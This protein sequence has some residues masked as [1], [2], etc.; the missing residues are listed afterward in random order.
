[1]TIQEIFDIAG[2]TISKNWLIIVIIL[3]LIQIAPVKISPWSWIGGWIGKIVG[4]RKLSDK[5]DNLENKMDVLDDKVENLEEKVDENQAI[6]S[7]VRI[8]RFGDELRRNVDHSKESFDQ[9][10]DDITR[11][12]QYCEDHP[13]FENDKTVLT[14]QV[15]KET[16]HKLYVEGK[17]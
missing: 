15:I 1:M 8:L 9:V 2:V 14:T 7:R 3:S 10:L 4:I 6:T 11:Y 17:I 16:Y 13:K 12:T 5:V